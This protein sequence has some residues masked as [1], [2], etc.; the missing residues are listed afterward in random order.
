MRFLRNLKI[1]WAMLLVGLLPSAAAL[2][3][4]ADLALRERD[5]AA[6]VAQLARRIEMATELSYVVHEFQRERGA[7]SVFV[8][9]A[10]AQFAEELADQ[11]EVTDAE[12]ASLAEQI[13]LFD[14]EADPAFAARLAELAAV[15]DRIDTVRAQVDALS[16]DRVAAVGAYTAANAQLIG[17]LTELAHLSPDP[18]IA[19]DMAVYAHLLEAK[20]RVGLERATGAHGFAQGRFDVATRDRFIGL[21][22]EQDTFLKLYRASASPDHAAYLEEV[23]DGEASTEVARMRAAAVERGLDGDISDVDVADWFEMISDK[24]VELKNVED[25]LGFD[26]LDRMA[27]KEEA[28]QAYAARVAALAATALLASTLLSGATIWMVRRAFAG[29]IAPMRAMATGDFETALPPEGA[30]EFGE[31]ARALRV[32]RDNGR[33]KAEMEAQEAE[34]HAAAMLRADAMEA[35][36]GSLG[37]AVAKAVEGDFSARVS[38]ETAEADLAHLAEGVNRLLA[39]V[40]DGLRE[41]VEMLQALAA[42]DLTARMSGTRGGAFA[43]LRD[44]ANATAGSLSR[45][46]AEIRAAAEASAERAARIEAGAGDLSARTESQAASLEQTAATTEQM[47]ANVRSNAEAL[48]EAEGVAAEATGA[49]GD[50]ERAA[51]SAVAAVARIEASSARIS[52][53]VAVIESIAF[54]TNLLA[55]NAAVEAA[56]AGE[57]GRGFAVVAFEVRTLAQRAS[58]SARDIAGLIG[59]SAGHVSEGVKMVRETGRAL[60]AIT[61]GVARLSGMI[62]DLSTAGREQAG[63]VEEINQAVSNMDVMTQQNAAMAEESARAARELSAGVAQLAQLAAAFRTEADARGARAA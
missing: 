5:R 6:E 36:K 30:N 37:A 56:R 29:V 57:A 16:V 31:V 2:W 51:E 3:F 4:A 62:A 34:R 24:I 47:S 53:I 38:T 1:T 50:G 40:D 32:F 35:L 8:G 52:E 58:E 54:Q 7:T 18:E 14:A 11:R 59:E 12:R 26:L 49:A 13:A 15:I 27:A 25:T 33:A 21:I 23:L 10:G 17:A 42:A 45:L 44:S 55:L 20:E 48:Q 60:G 19:G 41:T 9:S 43:T 61:A 63:G 28:A 22:A 46:V 39:T